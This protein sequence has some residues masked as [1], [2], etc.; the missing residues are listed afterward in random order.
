MEYKLVDKKVCYHCGE[1]STKS[2]IVLG[3][4]SFCCEGC[5][6]V[7][8]ILNKNDLCTYYDL[9]EHPGQSLKIKVREDKFAF[10]DDVSIQSKLIHFTDGKQTQVTF[11]LPQMHCSSCLWLLENIHLINPGIIASKVNFV[12]K[13]AFLVFDNDKT[14]LRKV[15]ETLTGIGYEPHISLQELETNNVRKVEKSKLYKLGIAGFCFANIM[16]M[17]FPEYLSSEGKVEEYIQQVFQYFIVALSLPVI[18]YSASEFF[19]AAWKGL[20]NKFLNIDA[21][22]ALAILI[23]FGR[24][25]YEIFTQT[26]AGYLDSMSGIV[27][28]MLLGRILQDKTY[29]SISFDR[30][31]KSFFPIAVNV[32]KDG[33]AVPTAIDKVKSG[34]IIQVYSHELIPVDGILSKGNAEIDYSFVSGESLPV[35]KEIGEIIYAGG[36]QTGGALEL[37]V[38]KEVSQSYLTNLWNKDAFKKEKDESKSFVHQLSKNFTFLV[39]GIAGIAAAYWYSQGENQL[40]WN[41]ITTVLIVACPCALLLSSTFTNGNILRILSKNKFYLRHPDVIEHISEVD[42]LVFD[43]TGTITTQNA[44]KVEYQGKKIS[45]KDL[46]NVAVLLSQSSHPL[47]KSVLEFLDLN[48]QESTDHFKVIP[49]KGTE[50]WM[51]DKLYKIGSFEFVHQ[52]VP[53]VPEGTSV[54]VKIDDEVFGAFRIIHNYRSG[55][56]TLMSKLKKQFTISIL[57]GDNSSEAST[58]KQVLGQEAI[59]KF[60]QKPEEKLAFIQTLQEKEHHSVMMIGD[61]LN[62]AGALKQSNVGIAI[63]ENSNSFTPACDGILDASRFSDLDKFINFAKAGKKIILFSFNLSI[64]YNIIGLYFAVQ[65][66]LSPLIAAILMPSSSISIILVTYGLSELAAYRSRLKTSDQQ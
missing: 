64:I 53:S 9:N 47:S 58:L 65:G 15:V 4:K 43:K 16:M 30:D 54:W 36:K 39:L 49:G 62:D 21:P 26:G 1:D 34:D 37:V 11:Y 55:F 60:N 18:F 14:T 32:L 12:K 52:V 33:N 56:T 25:L 38:V 50:G 5:K 41:T 13:E 17:S 28:F 66:T 42:Q 51:D 10:L 35:K 22:I 2:K 59:L 3:D 7:F 6:M 46:H 40:M 24:S 48:I 27:F 57:S 19:V 20:K 44:V 8:E 29:Q 23:T 45:P 31:Y 61:G 63:A